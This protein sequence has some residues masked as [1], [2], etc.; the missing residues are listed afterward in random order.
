MRNKV[1]YISVFL[2]ISI[3][4][5]GYAQKSNLS[6]LPTSNNELRFHVMDAENIKPDKTSSEARFS[7]D[8]SLITPDIF[9]N[10]RSSIKKEHRLCKMIGSVCKKEWSAGLIK[11]FSLPTTADIRIY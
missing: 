10:R 8:A 11:L 2:L 1:L 4:N 6:L 7:N 5:N 3:L 9:R